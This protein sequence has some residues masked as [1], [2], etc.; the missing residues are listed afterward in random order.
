[1]TL[2][3]YSVLYKLQGDLGSGLILLPEAT[4]GH[5]AT[6]CYLLSLSNLSFIRKFDICE[7][8]G[9]SVILPAV[10]LAA[11]RKYTRERRDERGES[12]SLKRREV[13]AGVS[14]GEEP[15]GFF[16]VGQYRV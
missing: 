4:G 1:M 12:K 11:E 13:E 10:W 2:S 9:S 8:V 6:R 15:G 5:A 16:D 3:R 14:R 7:V